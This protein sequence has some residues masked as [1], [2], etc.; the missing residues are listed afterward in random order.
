M[1]YAGIYDSFALEFF[2][3]DS[4]SGLGSTAFFLLLFQLRVLLV[5]E[6]LFC[7]CDDYL[8]L[9]YHFIIV[10]DEDYTLDAIFIHKYCCCLYLTE[11]E[12]D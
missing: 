1:V 6:L 8:W 2:A 10:L 7:F 9:W 5:T 3:S 12:E 4:F 11:E